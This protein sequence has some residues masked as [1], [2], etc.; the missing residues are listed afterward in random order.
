MED[1]GVK[2]YHYYALYSKR[3]LANA[4]DK[5]EYYIRGQSYGFRWEP[6]D[7]DEAKL[8]V[9]VKTLTLLEESVLK[10]INSIKKTSI[11]YEGKKPFYKKRKK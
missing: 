1:S 6:P 10:E 11:V 9:I 7:K 5:L 8:I 4:I 2:L 3:N